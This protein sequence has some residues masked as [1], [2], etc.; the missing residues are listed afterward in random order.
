MY[1]YE[2]WLT[3]ETRPGVHRAPK[4]SRIY[5]IRPSRR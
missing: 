5:N 1:I 4:Q 3:L 2:S